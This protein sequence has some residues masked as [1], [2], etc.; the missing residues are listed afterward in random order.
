MRIYVLCDIYVDYGQYDQ[1]TIIEKF[2]DVATNEKVVVRWA[3]QLVESN[4]A[5]FVNCKE[6]DDVGVYMNTVD[7]KETA[8]LGKVVNV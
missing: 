7:L 1:D 3:K 5:M 4:N 8:R 2:R 6:Y